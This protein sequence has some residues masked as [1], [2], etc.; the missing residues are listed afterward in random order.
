MAKPTRPVQV[1]TEDGDVYMVP[2]ETQSQAPPSYA[3]A[4]ADAVPSYFENTIHAPSGFDLDSDMM[5]EDLPSGSILI[6]AANLFTSFFFQ[7]VGFLLTYLL[8]TSH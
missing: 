6:F 3:D 2:E 4:Q 5:I 8:H 7:F 1:R